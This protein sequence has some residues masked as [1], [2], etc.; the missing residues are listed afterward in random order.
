MT[1]GHSLIEHKKDLIWFQEKII[2]AG[3]KLL[4]YITEVMQLE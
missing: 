3:L 1:S 4:N 2:G